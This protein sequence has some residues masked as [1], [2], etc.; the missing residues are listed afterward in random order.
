[1]KKAQLRSV[2]LRSWLSILSTHLINRRFITLK[3]VMENSELL[4]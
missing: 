2:I 4:V 3:L 1:M